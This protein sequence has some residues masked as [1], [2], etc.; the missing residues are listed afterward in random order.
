MGES[1]HEAGAK[2]EDGDDE[3]P[4]EETVQDAPGGLA[5]NAS[6]SIQYFG[7]LA[8]TEARVQSLRMT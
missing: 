5:I 7:K 1:L 6:G 4:S 2:L 8:G 3:D